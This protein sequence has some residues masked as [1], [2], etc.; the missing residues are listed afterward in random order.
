MVAVQARKSGKN[1]LSLFRFPKEEKAA[2]YDK[3]YSLLMGK[4]LYIK[5]VLNKIA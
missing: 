4:Y 2:P 1:V 3:P 5:M